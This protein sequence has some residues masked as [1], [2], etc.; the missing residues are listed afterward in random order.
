MF[1]SHKNFFKKKLIF[2]YKGIFNGKKN[3]SEKNIRYINEVKKELI[4][5]NHKPYKFNFLNIFYEKY[6]N[7]SSISKIKKIITSD[8][9]PAPLVIQH[10]KDCIIRSNSKFFYQANYVTLPR[11]YIKLLKTKGFKLNYFKCFVSWNLYLLILFLQSFNFF[12]KIIKKN[13]FKKNIKNF[14]Q[15]IYFSLPLAKLDLKNIHSQNNF[16]F[17][18]RIVDYFKIKNKNIIFKNK[19]KNEISEIESINSNKILIRDDDL[20]LFENYFQ[21]VF[22]I[23]WFLL[24]SLFVIFAFFFGNYNYCLNFS[25]IIKI[26][27]HKIT[28]LRYIPSH[29]FFEYQGNLDKPMWVPFLEEYGT[30]FYIFHYSTNSEGYLTNKFTPIDESFHGQEAIVDHL[31]WDDYQRDIFQKINKNLKIHNIGPMLIHFQKDYKEKIIIPDRYI[32]IFDITPKRLIKNL[33]SSLYTTINSTNMKLF[34]NDI[35]E[36]A[37]E[38]NINIIFKTKRNFENIEN[39]DLQLKTDK[40]YLKNITNLNYHD[41]FYIVPADFDL[42]NLING[43]TACISFPYT[44]VGVLAKILGKKS[45]FYD[46]SLELINNTN[47]SNGVEVIAGKV[48]LRNWIEN[49]NKKFN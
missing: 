49:L 29:Y 21:L 47:F 2:Y 36:L 20:P 26:K 22:F 34:L 42:I 16:F 32:A 44:S 37:K 48:E 9:N 30:K 17:L 35:S 6:L 31:V 46:P 13:F 10:V 11:P 33:S 15:F 43:S 23:L 28:N 14:N 8:V 41:N 19:Y 40:S 25:D 3:M 4:N 1:F 38:N 24:F 39:K 18:N 5:L 12:F 7:E 27:I 45:I